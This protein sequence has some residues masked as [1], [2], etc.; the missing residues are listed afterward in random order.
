MSAGLPTCRSS[1]WPGHELD[2]Q[3]AALIDDLSDAEID[4]ACPLASFG[5]TDDPTLASHT[6]ALLNRGLPGSIVTPAGEACISL[7]RACS[8]WPSGVWMDGDKRTVPD[9]SSFALQHWSH[10]FEY[11]LMAGQLDWRAAGFPVAGQQ[12]SH[13][14]LTCD[15]GLH[16]GPLP[17]EL[18][19][20]S[21]TPAGTD[22]MTMK[23]RGNP[24]A[25][26]SQPDSRDGVTVRLRGLAD[27]GEP[28]TVRLFTGHRGRHDHRRARAG[29]RRCRRLWRRY[30]LGVGA[31]GRHGHPGDRP[32]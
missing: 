27:T 4:A 3:I 6:V 15:T 8:A 21:V 10:T 28:A 19:L 13:R 17:A 16:T 11:A 32:W 29:R 31:A 2:S 18:S 14:L 24:L 5:A 9:G 7:M 26:V 30:R 20:A 12:Y 25:P 23:P 22:L 1:S